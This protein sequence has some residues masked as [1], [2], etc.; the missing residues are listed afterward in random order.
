MNLAVF[1]CLLG[2]SKHFMPTVKTI[3][4]ILFILCIYFRT[5]TVV[6]VVLRIKIKIG[7]IEIEKRIKKGVSIMMTKKEKTKIT[8]VAA[9]QAKIK[10]TKVLVP[11]ML[12][13]FCICGVLCISLKF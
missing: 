10:S 3:V 11:G 6:V 9:V 1:N 2:I 7:R 5:N 13:A 8:K 4:F 12:F